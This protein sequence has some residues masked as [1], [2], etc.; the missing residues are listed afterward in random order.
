MY[1]REG[2]LAPAGTERRVLQ[3]APELITHDLLADVT[4]TTYICSDINPGRYPHARPLPLRLPEGLDLFSEKSFDYVIHNHV[5][6]RLPGQWVDHV[7]PFRRVL[8]VGGK[9]IF[10]FPYSPTWSPD[11]T[12]E[13]GEHL[14]SDAERLSVFGQSDHVRKFGLDF[15]TKL[16]AMPGAELSLDGISIDHKRAIGGCVRDWAE[17]VFI[18]ERTS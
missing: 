16:G 7:E 2:L 18:W 12:I 14:E 11:E 17:T 3:F 15:A 13:G 8:K 4:G 6:E 5:W 10:T 9:M 1:R